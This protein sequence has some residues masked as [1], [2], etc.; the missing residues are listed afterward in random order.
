MAHFEH[1][2]LL[3][4]KLDIK[5]KLVVSKSF[6]LVRKVQVRLDL[7]AERDDPVIKGRQIEANCIQL[8][9]VTRWPVGHNDDDLLRSYSS[10]NLLWYWVNSGLDGMSSNFRWRRETS[11]LTVPKFKVTRFNFSSWLS[12]C[13]FRDSS[14]VSSTAVRSE[15]A[16]SESWSNSHSMRFFSSR[17]EDLKD[18]FSFRSES[19]SE[20]KF[21][22]LILSASAWIPRDGNLDLLISSLD[23]RILAICSFSL[24]F[25][26]L[27]SVFFSLI[28][29]TI[30]IA[31]KKI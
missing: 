2:L 24:I 8:A 5:Q 29:L 9:G 27:N 18:D 23:S 20:I 26:P 3:F 12:S 15:D 22:L 28:C 11:R 25:S 30:I 17:H 14:S 10:R 1:H 16:S 4:F 19:M 6:G 31:Y 7:E 21:C 13:W